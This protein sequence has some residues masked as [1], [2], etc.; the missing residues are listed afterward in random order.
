V[1]DDLRA[2]LERCLSEDASPQVLEVHLPPIREIIINLLQGLKLKQAEYKQYLLAQRTGGGGGSGHRSR[3]SRS[4]RSNTS[5]EVSGHRRSTTGSISRRPVAPPPVHDRPLSRPGSMVASPTIGAGLSEHD[6][7]RRR[8]T[9]G[10]SSARDAG[11]TPQASTDGSTVY[12]SVREEEEGTPPAPAEK[13]APNDIVRHS[14]VDGPVPDS[15]TGQTVTPT[16]SLT[17]LASTSAVQTPVTATSPP[18]SSTSRTPGSARGRRAM[19]AAHAAAEAESDPSLRALKSR[20]ALERRASKRFS[21]Y[22]FNKMGVGTPQGFGLGMGLSSLGGAAMSLH[23]PSSSPLAERR[24]TS[25]AQRA[26]KRLVRGISGGPPSDAASSGDEARRP[27]GADGADAEGLVPSGSEELT[28]GPLN[29]KSRL[30]PHLSPRVQG[31]TSLAPPPVD[32]SNANASSTESLPYVDAADPSPPSPY[33]QMDAV[34]PVP[35]LPTAAERKKLD[36]AQARASAPASNMLSLFLQLGRQ[37]RRAQLEL[38]PGAAGRGLSVGKLRMLF[39]DRFGYSP[40]KEDFP[41]IYVK[42]VPSG[43]SYELEDLNE[44]QEGA[45]LTLNIERGCSREEQEP[46]GALTDLLSQRSTR[47]S[48][49]LISCSARSRGSCAI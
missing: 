33:D 2:C 31:S 42:D 43:V 17:Q 8:G 44:L 29:G 20:D 34:P 1:P 9:G 46:C 28:P 40:R 4:E 6:E 45:V 41:T 18:L 27:R 30:S 25:E 12:E 16:T 35:P 24:T 32:T 39:M 3:G 49:T 36:A 23:S 14:L 19:A 15:A 11:M 7:P 48:S 26:G 37:T 13:R 5:E 10:S 21:A 22:T 38:L 47:S